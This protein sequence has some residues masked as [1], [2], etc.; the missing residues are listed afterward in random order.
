MKGI[1]ELNVGN[2]IHKDM[3]VDDWQI[4]RLK[5]GDLLLIREEFNREGGE[6]EITVMGIQ[7]T[8]LWLRK[9]GFIYRR[10]RAGGQDQFA[11]YG[12]WEHL[13]TGFSLT[14]SDDGTKLWLSRQYEIEYVHHLQNL[15]LILTGK[16]LKAI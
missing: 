4:I 13:E 12:Q 11:G 14:G 5:I 16:E 8:K 10:P 6:D 15:H 7:V 3:S 9:L 1:Q 2:Y